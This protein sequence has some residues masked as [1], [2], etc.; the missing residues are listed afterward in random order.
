MGNAIYKVSDEFK[1]WWKTK[2]KKPDEATFARMFAWEV[3]ELKTK[4]IDEL[5]AKLAAEDM[6]CMVCDWQVKY[7]KCDQPSL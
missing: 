4:E 3:W 2:C 5:K 6:V 7:C 1:T